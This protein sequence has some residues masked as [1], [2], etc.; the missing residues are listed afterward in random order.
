MSLPRHTQIIIEHLTT[1]YLNGHAKRELAIHGP[2]TTDKI[3]CGDVHMPLTN[4][5]K[6]P[7]SQN[8]VNK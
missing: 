8:Y 3:Q 2:L 4:T 6:V 5:Q 7:Y 1:R